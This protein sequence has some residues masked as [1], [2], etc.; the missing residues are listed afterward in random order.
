MKLYPL[1]FLAGAAAIF[2]VVHFVVWWF[3]RRAERRRGAISLQFPRCQICGRAATVTSHGH[4][5]FPD[6]PYCALHSP[7]WR[8]PSQDGT[9]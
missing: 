9:P 3:R 7:A 5:G 8:E 6:G 2:L 4:K 1:A